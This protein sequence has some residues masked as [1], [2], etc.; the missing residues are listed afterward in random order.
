ML[1]IQ[2]L[3]H[4]PFKSCVLPLEQMCASSKIFTMFTLTLF[5]PFSAFVLFFFPFPFRIVHHYVLLSTSCIFFFLFHTFIIFFFFVTPL[6]FFFP[7]FTFSD[8]MRHALFVRVLLLAKVGLSSA[9]MPF[10][11][12]MSHC[13]FTGW[14]LECQRFPSQIGP[15]HLMTYT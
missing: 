5:F 4:H 2:C 1:Y 14:V 11:H 15:C 8:L 12:V 13:T 10:A 6:Y 3:F 9:N 7:F